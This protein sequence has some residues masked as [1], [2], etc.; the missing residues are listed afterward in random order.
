MNFFNKSIE[1]IENELKTDR[2]NG[3][4]GSHIEEIREK[5]GFNELKGK[6]KQSILIKFLKVNLFISYSI[7]RPFLSIL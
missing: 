2:D 6:K 1:E 5:Y 3:L 4:K 7:P